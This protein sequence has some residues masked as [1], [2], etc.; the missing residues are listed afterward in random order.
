MLFYKPASLS[1]I[2]LAENAMPSVMAYA[3]F[4]KKNFFFSQFPAQAV[5]HNFRFIGGRRDLKALSLAFFLGF[6]APPAGSFFGDS[7]PYGDAA[8][9]FF[10][11]PDGGGQ[12]SF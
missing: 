4:Q 2:P 9:R 6:I 8:D 7:I 10:F 11:P 12:S 5:F 1:L 3:N